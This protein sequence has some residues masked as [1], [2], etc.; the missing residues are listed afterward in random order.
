MANEGHEEQKFKFEK[1]EMEIEH[2]Q[3]KRRIASWLGKE[4]IAVQELNKMMKK[5][6]E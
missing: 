6:M 2:A 5:Q 4:T 1:E 3:I